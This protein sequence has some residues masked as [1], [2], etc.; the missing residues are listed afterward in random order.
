MNGYCVE[1]YEP[2][3][4]GAGFISDTVLVFEKDK[5]NIFFGKWIDKDQEIKKWHV[6]H[7]ISGYNPKISH[8]MIIEPPKI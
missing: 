7:G 6:Y 3:I 1:E 2:K 4:V 8:F 5:G